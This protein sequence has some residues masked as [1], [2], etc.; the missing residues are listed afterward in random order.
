MGLL[1]TSVLNGVAVGTKMGTGLVLNKILAVY[2]GPAGYAV[3]GQLQNVISITTTFASGAINTGVT[4]YTAEYHDQ[5]AKLRSLWKTAGTFTV[6]GAFFIGL[7]IAIFRNYISDQFLNNIEYSK[8][9]V[10]LAACLLFISLNSLLL[11]ILAGQK[12]V[13]R[14]VAASIAGSLISLIT[15][16]F[17]AWKYGLSGVLAALSLGQGISFGATVLLCRKLEW[18]TIGG[19]AGRVNWEMARKLGHYVLMAIATATAVPVTQI[20]IRGQIQEVYS[21]SYAGY[22]DAINKISTIYLTLATTTLSLYYLPRV[23][24]IRKKHELRNEIWACF[25]IVVPVIAIASCSI[26]VLRSQLVGLLFT[27]EFLPMTGL[28][29]W[30]MLGDVFKIASWLFA[31]VVIGKARTAVFV[32][33]EIFFSVSLYFLTVVLMDKMGPSGFTAAYAANYVLYFLTMYWLVMVKQ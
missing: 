3:I 1:K 32:S 24:E 29:G 15:S 19:L 2:V 17:L 16:G 33:T 27:P 22:W 7:I 13:K 21:A 25:R 30:Q 18:C 12:S 14:Y 6:G 8:A 26:F 31:Y 9:L 11:A 4:K 10:W 23:A 5:P 28:M 20:L